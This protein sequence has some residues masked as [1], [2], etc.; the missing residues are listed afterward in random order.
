MASRS[1]MRVS[2]TLR[3]LTKLRRLNLLG[4]QITD[5]SADILAGFKELRELNIYR[6]QLDQRRDSRNCAESC[7]NLRLLDV[8]YSDITSAG[9]DAFRKALPTCRIVFVTARAPSGSRGAKEQAR[10]GGLDGQS[11]LELDSIPR[12]S[13]PDV[14]MVAS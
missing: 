12:R 9:V 5:A 3:K 11:H 2:A 7:P 14:P 13:G 8:R 10:P 4:A 6:S 1:P